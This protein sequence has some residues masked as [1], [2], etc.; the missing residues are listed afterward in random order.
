MS[1]S[2]SI[3]E[4]LLNL[5]QADKIRCQESSRTEAGKMLYMISE[6]NE[7]QYMKR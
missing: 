5:L 6:K 7:C 3:A 4:C 2:L 1:V